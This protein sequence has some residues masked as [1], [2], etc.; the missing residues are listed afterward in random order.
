MPHRRV[1]LLLPDLRPVSGIPQRLSFV[2]VG[3][4][5][6]DR[7]R[8]FYEGLGWTPTISVDNFCAFEVGGTMLGL[9]Q[10]ENLAEE[11][12]AEPP[13]A[14]QWSGWALAHNVA[15]RE[16]VDGMWQRWVDAGAT[17]IK[18]P[19][20]HPY[21]PRSGMVADP[22]GNRWEIAFAEGVSP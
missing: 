4:R 1:L 11:A 8:A 9:Y 19:V 22:E 14:G 21:G 3:V 20:D 15:T 10:V 13:P 6:V 5:D 17:P 18:A 16:E 12:A 2:T 7:M